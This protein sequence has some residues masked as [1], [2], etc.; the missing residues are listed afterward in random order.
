MPQ[1][2]EK[3]PKCGRVGYW[4]REIEFNGDDDYPDSITVWY[5]CQTGTTMLDAT[6]NIA[7]GHHGHESQADDVC[8]YETEHITYELEKACQNTTK[9]PDVDPVKLQP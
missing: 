5:I 4:D 9:M 6:L 3:C 7:A 2:P 1:I 8:G